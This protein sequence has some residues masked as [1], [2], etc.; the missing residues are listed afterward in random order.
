MGIAMLD[1]VKLHFFFFFFF[2][3]GSRHLASVLL[4]IVV[5]FILSSALFISSS[6]KYTVVTAL[7]NEAD[8]T[9]QRVRGGR[10][11]DIPMEWREIL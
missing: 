1:R 10:L 3:E 5:I 6:L 4:S 2:G 7:K 11:V 9:V 8:M